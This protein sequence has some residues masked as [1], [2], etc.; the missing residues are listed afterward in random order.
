MTILLALLVS[1]AASAQEASVRWKVTSEQ[2]SEQTWNLTFSGKIEDG[3]H[4]YGVNPGI[5]NPVEVEYNTPVKAGPLQEVTEPQPYKD[6]LVFFKEAVFSQEVTADPGMTV[7]GIINMGSNPSESLMKKYSSDANS[8]YYHDE[9]P[10]QAQNCTF[11]A[12]PNA[13]FAD[14]G[15]TWCVKTFT[16]DNCIIS[17]RGSN[18][19]SNK[20]RKTMLMVMTR[21][22]GEDD[23]GGDGWKKKRK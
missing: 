16:I 22:R 10:V 13:F 4:I 6:D 5:G 8:S 7:E 17:N 15:A 1:F 12:V 23:D 9:S 14:G 11:K 21:R 3:K 20:G 19:R 2:V 18:K